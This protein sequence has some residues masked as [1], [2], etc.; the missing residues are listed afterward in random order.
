MTQIVPV[1]LITFYH[2]RIS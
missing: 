1:A 2:T